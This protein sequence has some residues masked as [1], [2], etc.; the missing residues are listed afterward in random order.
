VEINTGPWVV[1]SYL[2]LPFYE[3]PVNQCIGVAYWKQEITVIQMLI[4][5][6][7]VPLAC[8]LAVQTLHSG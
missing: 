1:K 5:C 8:I 6:L 2:K 4:L 3:C 7:Y